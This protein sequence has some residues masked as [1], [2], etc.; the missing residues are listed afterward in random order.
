MFV[1]S[2]MNG[3]VSYNPIYNNM[4]FQN[5]MWPRM[6]PSIAWNSGQGCWIEVPNNKSN[7]GL[8]LKY[9]KRKRKAS[10]RKKNLLRKKRK[11]SRKNRKSRK[12]NIRKK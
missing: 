10:R 6:L 5:T 9:G 7:L 2:N 1:L 8:K 4:N 11:S 3:S 12:R